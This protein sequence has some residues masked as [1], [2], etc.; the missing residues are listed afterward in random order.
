MVLDGFVE[1]VLTFSSISL[2]LDENSRLVLFAIVSTCFW[3]KNKIFLDQYEVFYFTVKSDFFESS[4]SFC[5]V[6]SN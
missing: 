4:F 5:F 6:F 3:I 2:S 1:C